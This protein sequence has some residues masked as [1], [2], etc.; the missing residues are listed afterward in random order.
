MVDIGTNRVLYVCQAKRAALKVLKSGGNRALTPLVH[1][2]SLTSRPQNRVILGPTDLFRG[3]LWPQVAPVGSGGGLGPCSA[4][5]GRLYPQYGRWRFK[6]PTEFAAGWGPNGP[7][8]EHGPK[9]P[10]EPTGPTWGHSGPLNRSVGPEITRFWGRFANGNYHPSGV[11]AYL[12][13]E[14]LNSW[15]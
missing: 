11:N 15:S 3:P 9:P 2:L 1:Q 5:G 6:R 14:E 7:L 13:G 12:G 8:A 4:M 10:P